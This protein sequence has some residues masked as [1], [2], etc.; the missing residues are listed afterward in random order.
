MAKVTVQAPSRPGQTSKMT[1]AK[2]NS[3]FAV[4]ER[5]GHQLTQ[6]HRVPYSVVHAIPGR[7]RF[8]VPRLLYDADYAIR[9]QV[10]LEA[11]TLVT[12][13]RINR[14]AASVVI[15]YKSNVGAGFTK[16]LG[17]QAPDSH[18]P[19]SDA[20][21]RSRLSLLIQTASE[22]VV[23]SSTQSSIQQSATDSAKSWSTGK[24][25]AL[26]TTL[27]VL[28]GPLGLPVPPIMLAG[29]IAIATLPVA[30]RAIEGITAQRRLNI[31]FLD[32]MAIA[33]TTLQGQFLTPSLML[34]LIEI[35][36]NIRDRSQSQAIDPS[37]HGYCC[38]PQLSGHDDSRTVW[39]Q[40]P[41]G[42]DG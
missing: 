29:T 30:Q 13:I 25:S 39:S 28:G 16:N 27:A 1:V 19:P 11:D 2:Q 9:L 7:V 8:R 41:G 35:G 33:I 20:S 42:N 37:K 26:A 34:G 10:L 5:N 18:Y 31:D 22:V 23:L 24:L 4:V 3:K 12:S 32:L 15:V 17:F 6:P 38:A 21:I 14:A 36:E 40:P